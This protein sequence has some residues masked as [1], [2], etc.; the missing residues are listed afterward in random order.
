MVNMYIDVL[1]TL[2]PNCTNPVPF[3]D[4]TMLVSVVLAFMVSQ[5]TLVPT[6]NF[7]AIPTP[8]DKITDPVVD[9]EL[10]VVLDND[11]TEVLVILPV[12][13]G[14][15]E[16]SPFVVFPVIAS[17]TKLFVVVAPFIVKPSTVAPPLINNPCPVIPPNGSGKVAI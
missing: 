16:I 10:S 15:I 2:V 1:A 11:N 5:L 7:F 12:P 14:I 9:D 13:F 4:M 6:N 17:T 3:P 8:P